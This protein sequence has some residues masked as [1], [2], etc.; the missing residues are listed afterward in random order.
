[1]NAVKMKLMF[2]RSATA[3]VELFELMTNSVNCSDV[4]QCT[5]NDISFVQIS[6]RFS[7]CHS[8]YRK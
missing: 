4:K 3:W 7:N 2:G 6:I 8:A 1:M 5:I